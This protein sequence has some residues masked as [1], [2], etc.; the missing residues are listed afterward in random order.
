MG[1]SLPCLAGDGIFTIGGEATVEWLRDNWFFLLMFILF[2]AM[3]LF[4]HGMHGGHGGHGSHGAEDEQTGK[5]GGAGG[6][7]EKGGHGCC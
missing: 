2:I 4:G 1:R 6:K 3:H 5:G 7:A